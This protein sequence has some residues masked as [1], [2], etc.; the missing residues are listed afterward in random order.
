VRRSPLHGVG[1]DASGLSGCGDARWRL[2][3]QVEVELLNQKFLIGVELGIAAQDQHAAC[4]L[5]GALDVPTEQHIGNVADAFDPGPE[6]FLKA[7]RD[8][9]RD[10]GYTD[11]RNIRLEIRTAEGRTRPRSWFVSPPPNFQYPRSGTRDP[12]RSRMRPVSMRG[13]ANSRRYSARD[14][15]RSRVFRDRGVRGAIRR[16]IV[17]HLETRKGNYYRSRAD[18]C[19]A[20]RKIKVRSERLLEKKRGAG[21]DTLENSRSHRYIRDRPIG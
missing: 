7:L 12:V 3:R 5:A 9:L 20:R 4:H 16:P 14:S 21:C 18:L 17:L 15:V 2:R 10:V 13:R 1:W 8:G 11:G 6:L 19:F